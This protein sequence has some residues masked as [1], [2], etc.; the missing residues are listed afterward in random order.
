MPQEGQTVMEQLTDAEKAKIAK[1]EYQR[2]WRQ[3]HKDRQ[4]KYELDY[5]VK[6]YDE[7]HEG[8]DKDDR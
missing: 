8:G 7:T 5:W 3:E 6:V 2:K 1:K 4:K